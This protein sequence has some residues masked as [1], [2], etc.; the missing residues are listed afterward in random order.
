MDAHTEMNFLGQE[1]KILAQE[2]NNLKKVFED[3]K[4]EN[5]EI[6]QEEHVVREL[7]KL[8]L[9]IRK[10][11]QD[12]Q[13]HFMNLMANR[14]NASYI[15][16]NLTK[17]TQ[18]YFDSQKRFELLERLFSKFQQ[19]FERQS[20]DEREKLDLFKALNQEVNQL[21]A[22][23]STLKKSFVGD[24][25]IYGNMSANEFAQ[26]FLAHHGIQGIRI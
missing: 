7:E 18:D 26:K 2:E 14:T 25:Q 9:T 1:I 22:I 3:L 6:K 10:D 17:I 12:L 8:I 16:N 23:R 13:A 15:S 11:L 21:N 5:E 20:K 24:A 19:L 4:R